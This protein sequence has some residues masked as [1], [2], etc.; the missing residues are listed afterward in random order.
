MLPVR[1]SGFD[2]IVDL[3]A[4][5]FIERY[6]HER[7]KQYTSLLSPLSSALILDGPTRL[8]IVSAR[9]GLT[10]CVRNRSKA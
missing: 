9:P 6:R 10:S 8:A 7:L 5:L 4:A 3:Q 1:A 2:V